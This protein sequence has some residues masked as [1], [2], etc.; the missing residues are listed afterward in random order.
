MG[1]GQWPPGQSRR[2]LSRA[3]C[4]PLFPTDTPR[5]ADM[6]RR[7]MLVR[8]GAAAVTLGLGRSAIPLG[9][10]V[11]ADSPKRRL[12][13]FTRSQGFE[14]DVVKRPNRLSDK[15]LKDF[16]LAKDGKLSFPSSIPTDFRH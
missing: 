7:D 15:F 13:M 6:N 4:L 10:A 3:D 2:T 14:H 12:L 11:A 16:G 5:S 8:T 9:W 1:A